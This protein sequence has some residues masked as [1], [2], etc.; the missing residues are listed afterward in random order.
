MLTLTESATTVVK[1]IVEQSIGTTDGGLRINSEDPASTE[2]AVRVVQAPEELDAVVEN[3]GARVYL[4]TNAV[5]ALGDKV[6]DAEIGD[7]GTARFAI[8]P[9]A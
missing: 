3:D 7:D 9:Q 4:G 6:L 8:A 2:F 1:A 5:L